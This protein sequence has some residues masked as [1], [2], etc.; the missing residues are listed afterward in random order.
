MAKDNMTWNQ[1]EE[2][3]F[4]SK[5]KELSDIDNLR[6]AL[7]GSMTREQYAEMKRVSKG[8]PPAKTMRQK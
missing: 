1:W 8:P 3:L 6:V 5:D 7:F 4:T 2:R